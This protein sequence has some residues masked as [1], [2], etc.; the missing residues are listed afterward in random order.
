MLS[1]RLSYGRVYMKS[2]LLPGLLFHSMLVYCKT[3][4]T[5]SSSAERVF[6]LRIKLPH[7]YIICTRYLLM[8]LYKNWYAACSN[9]QL[10]IN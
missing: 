7:T 10:N 4:Q 3:K 8:Y 1:V 9:E 2:L 6:T 5:V